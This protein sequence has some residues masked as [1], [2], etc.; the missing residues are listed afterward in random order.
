MHEPGI[1]DEEEG[2]QP[3]RGPLGQGLYTLCKA[4]AIGGGLLFV[5]LVLMSLVSI[6]GRKLASMPIPGDIEIMQ[7][8]TAVASAAMLAYCE[9]MRHHL[10]VDFFTAKLSPKNKNRLDALSHLLLALFSVLIA[11]RTSVAA[12]SLHEAGEKSMM[13]LLPV[14][15]A[16]AL[17]LPSFVLLAAAGFYNMS[18]YW[19]LSAQNE[20]T[21]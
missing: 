14:W 17:L 3:L 4:F 11:W 13:L 19:K 20:V 8:G 5:L 21:A 9:M 15:P 2:A 18:H 12:I 10:R 16:V 1:G 7:M 6:V